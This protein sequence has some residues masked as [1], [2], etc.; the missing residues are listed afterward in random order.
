MS[1]KIILLSIVSL[2]S[3]AFFSQGEGNNWY[4]GN[5]AG[6]SFSTDPPTLLNDGH[7]KTGEGCASVSGKDGQLVFYTDGT[8][9][10]DANHNLMPNGSGLLGS[11]SSTQSAVICPKPGTY[12]YG[13]QR[14]D[15]Y[16]IVTIAAISGP[17]GIRFTEVD[18]T[19][20]GGLGD[21]VVSNKN[22]HLFGTTTMEGANVTKHANG[23]DYWIIG[24]PVG[25]NNVLAFH[26]S[27][28]GV[29]L[30]PVVSSTG[31]V[32]YKGWGSIKVSPD[33]KIIGIATANNYN[34]GAPYTNV[35]DFDNA[36]GVVTHRYSSTKGGY[37]LEF[38]PNNKVLYATRLSDPNIYQYDLTTTTQA[39]F[40]A[41][42][43]I[44]GT[45][46]NTYNYQMCGLQLAPN[47]RIYAA[48]HNQTR[49][50]VIN[51]P[52][53][54]GT[55]CN[56]ND[57]GVS[58]A[59]V[60]TFAS[61]V[62]PNNANMRSNL[63][64]P[65]FPSFFVTEPV[66]IQASYLC[67]RDQTKLKLTD[68]TDMSNVD[69]FWGAVGSTLPVVPTTD[70]EPLINFSTPGDYAVLAVTYYPCFIDSIYDTIT[71][72]NVNTVN[73]GND[74]V[75]CDGNTVTLDAGTG[76]DYYEWHDGS[77]GQTFLADTT[78]TYSVKVSNIGS[79]LVVNGDFEDG[80]TGF[81]S[82]YL[83]YNSP[84]GGYI[85]V[86]QGGYTVS[87][88]SPQWGGNCSDHTTGSGNMMV[89]DAA[90][91]TNGIPGG[92]NLWCQTIEVSPNTDYVFSL[93]ATNVNSG[94]SAANL[95]FFVDGV[96]VG[97][98]LATTTASCNW[99]QIF[100]FWNSGNSTMVEV[101][102]KE[103]TYICSGADFAI[104]D[105]FFAELCDA[106]DDITVTVG[107]IPHAE[108]S[109]QDSCTYDAVVFTDAST[110]PS[111]EVIASYSWDVNNDGTEDYNI[112]NP[113]HFYNAGT[114]TAKLTVTS[115]N[116]CSKDTTMPVL[117][118]PQP[119]ANFTF[120][121]ECLY[122]SLS[123]VDGSSVTAPDMIAGYAWN[124][125]EN[126][127]PVVDAQISN[128]YHTYASAGTYIVTEIVTTT[129]GCLDTVTHQVEAYTIPVANFNV[130]DACLDAGANYTDNSSIANGS[131]V[132]WNWDFGD[133][134]LGTNQNETHTYVQD[135]IYT[136]ELVVTSDHNCKDTAQQD[137]TMYPMPQVAFT[138][139]DNCLE[140]TTDFI[141]NTQI[142]APATITMWAWDFGDGSSPV[143][144]QN[145]SYTY[146]MAGTYDVTLSVVSSDNCTGS[147]QQS[148]TIHPLP[149]VG[150]TA[151]EVCEN[152]PP[153]VFTNTSAIAS[154]T[155]VGFGWLFGDANGSTSMQENPV[156][157]YG[158]Q[159]EYEVTLAIVSNQGCTDTLT[160]TIKVKHKPTA[161]F[162][163]DTTGGCAPICVNF[164]SQ[165]LDSIG[166]AS[167]NWQF[168][169]GLGEGSH[170]YEGYCYEEAGTYDVKLIV[171]NTVG[172]YDTL[173]K[174]AL[175]NTYAYPTA[176]FELTPQETTITDAEI[177]FTNN[178]IDAVTWMWDF[179]DGTLDSIAYEPVHIYSDTGVYMVGL[180]VY[181]AN[182]CSNTVYHQV[183]IKPI[184]NIFVP[185]AFSPNGD[186]END[187][188]YVRGFLNGM[189]FAVYDRWGKK[190]FES[191]D[192]SQG[193]D[194]LI[195]GK[196]AV[197]G[198]YM[199][200]LQTT[201]NGEGKKF[202]GDVS[203]IR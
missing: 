37:S 80:N 19:L 158:E 138:V 52:N 59:G 123:F 88:L 100:Q 2:I 6:L 35:Y 198:V 141:D 180:T 159:G 188:L 4:F 7:L 197:E 99:T 149:Q 122:D 64:L 116:G 42:Q 87:T 105:I 139:Q 46:A 95:G 189:Y 182:G 50:G 84:Q 29:N 155:N 34:P 12:N 15:G 165:S 133:L 140:E 203:L 68:T 169:N 148:V 22:I 114:Y 74:T 44:V 194:G 132:A 104:D 173:Q 57:N 172:C 32:L 117:V 41:S 62:E 119:Q 85:N 67:Y 33:S 160:Q 110:I 48:L 162:V 199:W 184:E 96:Q 70:W 109:L 86:P 93:W 201:I 43:T 25:N 190:V 83:S 63:G 196:Q 26:I 157:N 81:S 54:L 177:T 55:A 1:I 53:I 11:S 82:E 8:Y 60:N 13:T 75:I 176:D 130:S 153:T 186:G 151:T 17:G 47:G 79:N 61:V 89:V 142:N 124:F 90:C 145:P 51:N 106:T 118:Y 94:Y 125:G 69:W 24:K 65:A 16:Y 128:P 168:E 107:E 102:I 175:I 164:A 98:T 144:L 49:L 134:N 39:A 135:G 195:E 111:P 27:P 103:L 136:V 161:I 3:I 191:K 91:G 66:E 147:L 156:F 45:T 129:N 166:I 126:P 21:V 40:L 171:Q 137:V 9:V 18:M 131:I 185:S 183:I 113:S 76:Y 14:Y 10:Y 121:N 143:A 192:Q 187:I 152:E 181:N 77:T 108:F 58:L 97:T 78:G 178:S 23:C 73:L 146:P 154:G 193:W 120:N 112:Q 5:Y 28:T 127:M 150:F 92:A 167:W 71:I 31:P 101:C 170:K 202:K 20:N 163:Q 200:Y 174:T 115:G 72:T 38:S 56:Y 36:T 179:T 30:T